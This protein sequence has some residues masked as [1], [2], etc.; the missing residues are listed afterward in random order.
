M[1]GHKLRDGAR[2]RLDGQPKIVCNILAR[3]RKFEFVRGG[4]PLGHFK[5]KAGN[6]LLSALNQKHHA[7]L[8]PVQFA[9]REV[10]QLPGGFAIPFGQRNDRATPDH[11]HG[12]MIDGLGGKLVRLTDLEAEDIAWKV[13][14]SDLA[15]TVAENLVGPHRTFGDFVHVIRGFALAEYFLIGS[16]YHMA[17]HQLHRAEAAAYQNGTMR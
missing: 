1:V 11:R 13:E 5:E 4:K 8:N 16:K 12:G 10:P 15:P 17:S 9:S 6:P 2:N 3:H 14:T 7:L